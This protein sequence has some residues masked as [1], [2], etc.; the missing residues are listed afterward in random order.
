MIFNLQFK[1]GNLNVTEA[2][3][4][5]GFKNVIILHASFLLR[6]NI[7]F[8]IFSGF[9]FMRMVSPASFKKCI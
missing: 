3:S 9:I 2:Y 8:G 5:I 6:V 1:K 7:K 4:R